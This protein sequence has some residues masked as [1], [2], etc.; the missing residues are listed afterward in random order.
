VAVA[1]PGVISLDAL[2]GLEAL[3]APAVVWIS[4]AAA[5]V[6]ALGNVGMRRT[7]ADAGHGAEA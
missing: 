3:W 4:L 2:F 5:V 1:G 7:S 6:L